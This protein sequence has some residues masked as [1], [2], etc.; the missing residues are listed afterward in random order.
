MS[1]QTA[2]SGGE[3]NIVLRLVKVLYSWLRVDEECY[4]AYY[5]TGTVIEMSMD[6]ATC[7]IE[8]KYVVSELYAGND[9]KLSL[10]SKWV[11]FEAMKKL[12]HPD[13]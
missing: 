6:L 4:C 2:E 1:T 11:K 9:E 10:K 3:G 7:R 5:D 12:P 13:L 8:L